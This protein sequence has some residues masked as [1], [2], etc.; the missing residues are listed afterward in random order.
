[1]TIEIPD[2]LYDDFV[3][4]VSRIQ[5]KYYVMQASEYNPIDKQKHLERFNEASKI[6]SIIKSDKP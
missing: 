6:L 4:A 1:M 2:I 3:N 5:D